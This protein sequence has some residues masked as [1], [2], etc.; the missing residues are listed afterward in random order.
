MDGCPAQSS[1]GEGILAAAAFPIPEPGFAQFSKDTCFVAQHGISVDRIPCIT[2]R[3]VGPV[4]VMAQN[5]QVALAPPWVSPGQADG[6]PLPGAAPV[7]RLPPAIPDHE[8]LRCIG[9]GSYGEVWL[10]RNIMGTY[11]AIKIVYRATFDS[12]R[13]YEREFKG[14][15]KFEPV[16]R[17]HESQVA[18]LHIGRNDREGYFY[19]V[20]ELAD[21]QRTGPQIEPES[22]MP[23]TLSSELKAQARVPADQCLQIGLAL[24][25][26][27]DHLHKYGLIHRD[28]KPSNIIFVNGR[29]KLADIGLVAAVDATCSFV[30]TE[31]YLPP[32]GPGTPQGDLYSLGKVLYEASTGKDRRDFPELPS[33]LESLAEEKSILE[34]NAVIV[35]ACQPLARQ[36]YQLAGQMHDDLL[37]LVAGKSV[38][39][40]HALERRVKVLTRAAAVTAAVMV[41]GAV[42]YYVAIREA[43]LARAARADAQERLWRSLLSEAKAQRLSDQAGRRSTALEAL[44]QA[45]AIRPSLELRNEAIACLALSDLRVARVW[46]VGPEGTYFGAHDPSYEHY[47]LACRTNGILSVRRTQDDAE[48]MRLAPFSPPA[49]EAPEA[50]YL[51][52]F[53]PDGRWLSVPHGAYPPVLEIWDL[54]RK[55]LVTSFPNRNCRVVAFSP[56]GR[57]AAISFHDEHDTNQPSIIYDLVARQTSKTLL[58]GTCPYY[59]RF[60]PS[61]RRLA[62]S[63][64]ESTE[65]RVYDLDSGTLMQTLPHP[66]PVAGIGW[67]PEGHL[68]ASG[69]AD[70]QVYLWDVASGAPAHVLPGHSGWPREVSFSSDGQF[71]AS[72]AWDGSLRFWDPWTGRT[73]FK[74]QVAGTTYGFGCSRLRYGYGPGTGKMGFLEL[75]PSRECRLIRPGPVFKARGLDCDFSPDGKWLLTVHEDG[76][77]VWDP[78]QDRPLTMLPVEGIRRAIFGHREGQLLLAT[79]QGLIERFLDCDASDHITA[80]ASERVLSSAVVDDLILDQSG[81]ALAAPTSTDICLLNL[82]VQTQTTL[83]WG[84]DLPKDSRNWLHP[85]LSP[86][87]T[88]VA[89]GVTASSGVALPLRIFRI[90][91]R[92]LV[93]EL[94]NNGRDG[95]RP[96]FSP[97]GKWLLTGNNLE[98]RLREVGTWRSPYALSRG[99]VGYDAFMAFSPDSSMVAVALTRDTVRLLKAATGDE[100]ATFEAPE[101]NDIYHLSFSPNGAYLAVTYRN[102]PVH[103]WDLRLVRRELT[104]MNLGWDSPPDHT[105]NESPAGR[106]VATE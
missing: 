69:C 51:L 20:M 61:G 25:T 93:C 21:D 15:Q 100:I 49:F 39:R 92:E 82:S 83:G 104:A 46:N 88:L 99:N 90:A 54:Q 36:R 33:Q 48:I 30:G 64:E 101:A 95:I 35:K 37:L 70:N 45:A 11:R 17:T 97:N 43:V 41:L 105:P 3:E 75:E 74:R 55:D 29:P 47:A 40:T 10:G 73:I 24:T 8:M 86:D 53:S 96:V 87:G 27:L 59:L 102:G 58:H 57:L 28:I 4:R 34:L 72:R 65:V 89:C 68:L 26:A 84:P 32:E 98:Y 7:C 63:T 14:L 6:S 18:V 16:S 80:A 94:P 44:K 38:L 13:P 60:D 81:A 78:H 52:G 56:D 1:V 50:A 91:T 103:F 31:G 85:T 5:E 106:P 23:R 19:H 42:P 79:D 77:R 22:Y 71:L 76:V 67:S 12:D 66:G 2:H 9:R 62:T